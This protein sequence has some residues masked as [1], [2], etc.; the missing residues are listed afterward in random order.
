MSP[1]I[2]AGVNR[3]LILIIPMAN[4]KLITVHYRLWCLFPLLTRYQDELKLS[5]AGVYIEELSQIPKVWGGG[6]EGVQRDSNSVRHKVGF[7]SHTAIYSAM[8]SI[9]NADLGY[10]SEHA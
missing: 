6:G 8:L 5:F 4:H 1:K 7:S 2:Y 9:T 3:V 10:K